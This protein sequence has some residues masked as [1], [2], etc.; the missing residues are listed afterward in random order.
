MRRTYVARAATTPTPPDLVQAM[1]PYCSEAPGN[2]SS[3]SARG[4]KAN[5]AAEEARIKATEFIGVRCDQIVFASGSTE[6]DDRALKGLIYSRKHNRNTA[7]SVYSSSFV[8]WL[9]T[10]ATSYVK[11]RIG[12]Q[13]LTFRCT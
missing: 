11:R 2:P 7:L 1:L 3:I 8:T 13:L 12:H 5:G 10:H 6:A 9:L 4:R